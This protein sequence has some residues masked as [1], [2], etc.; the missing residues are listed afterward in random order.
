[1]NGA[2]WVIYLFPK[3]IWG[4]LFRTLSNLPNH[5]VVGHNW[6]DYSHLFTV[7]ENL[8]FSNRTS[9]VGLMAAE[10]FSG[11]TLCTSHHGSAVGR[12]QG[13]PDNSAI[14]GDPFFLGG[15]MVMVISCDPCGREKANWLPKLPGRAEGVSAERTFRGYFWAWLA[16]F[17]FFFPVNLIGFYHGKSPLHG[18]T[19]IFWRLFCIFSKHL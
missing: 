15:E 12:S 10:D 11:R 9:F 13:L 14:C 4:L 3:L 5:R 7:S 8:S 6:W 18:Y 2:I 19:T 16:F 1:M 17:M